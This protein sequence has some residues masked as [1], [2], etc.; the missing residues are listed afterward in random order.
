[1]HTAAF[2]YVDEQAADV[3]PDSVIVECGSRDVNGSVRGL[4]PLAS[5]V[6]VDIEPG[7][8][9]DVVVD[10]RR[11]NVLHPADVV[12]CCEV[13]EHDRDP[14]SLLAKAFQLLRPGGTLIMTCAGTGRAE[15]SAFDGGPL[16]DGEHYANVGADELAEWLTAQGWASY[17]IDVEGDDTRCTAWR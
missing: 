7:P 8:G 13:L 9:V 15:H 3:A 5:Y 11:L 4:F 10:F 12:V 2:L 16:R 1:V 17:L 14:K 6:G